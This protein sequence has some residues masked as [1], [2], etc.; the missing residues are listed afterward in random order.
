MPQHIPRKQL[1]KDEVR[2]TLAHGADAVLSHQTLTLYILIVAI[3]VAVGVFGWKTYS[4]RQT[5]KASAEFDSAMKA[6]QAPV[7]TPPPGETSYA[8][9]PQKFTTAA[10]EFADVA[11]KY[12]RTHAGQL[13]RYY[14]ALSYEKLGKTDDAR[15][16]LQDIANGNDAEVAALAQL[17]LAGIDDRTG[18]DAEAVKLYE[19][20][21]AQPSVLVP[22]PVPM[23]ALAEHYIR[24]K[25]PAEAA[26]LYGQIKADYPDTPMAE[27]ADQALALLGG[28][29]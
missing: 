23:M 5:V 19:A 26:K 20:L 24:V 25:D 15:K 16:S 13:A 1:K 22:K 4:E 14:A 17:E 18:Q 7:G 12:P 10:K 8:S 6:F 28:K 29:S 21:I 9:D 3:L 11:S 27:Q 2:D